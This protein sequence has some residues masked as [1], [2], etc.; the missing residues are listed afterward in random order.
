MLTLTALIFLDGDKKIIFPQSQSRKQFIDSMCLYCP[1]VASLLGVQPGAELAVVR[2]KWLCFLQSV[3]LWMC[4]GIQ[5]WPA[6]CLLPIHDLSSKIRITL[7]IEWGSDLAFPFLL[8]LLLCPRRIGKKQILSFSFLVL[9]PLSRHH[10]SSQQKDDRSLKLTNASLKYCQNWGFVWWFLMSL[11]QGLW[12]IVMR[13]L[14]NSVFKEN[15]SCKYMQ[16][17][18][19]IEFIFFIISCVGL[20]FRFVLETLL[21]AQVCSR[22]CW[23]RLHSIEALSAH[24]TIPPG[25]RLGVHKKMRG[26][27]W[28][29]L[30]KGNSRSYG[31]LI[32]I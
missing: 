5:R 18:A 27:S 28:S 30:T 23:A 26:N 17:F 31:I 9:N 1:L 20:C 12:L 25:R 19:R 10:L 16:V 13:W 29:Y 32:I 2:S 15:I 22:Y 3:Y 11:K 24:Y 4:P 14:M 8:Y 21:K 7:Q 6:Y